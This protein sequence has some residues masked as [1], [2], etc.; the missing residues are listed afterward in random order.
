ML[1]A[2]ERHAVRGEREL[3]YRTGFPAWPQAQLH[4]SPVYP[5]LVSPDTIQKEPSRE[6]TSRRLQGA[7]GKAQAVPNLNLRGGSRAVIETRMKNF[8]LR[9]RV[10]VVIR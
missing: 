3:I 8:P 10:A 4:L 2:V 9:R 5:Q 6:D 7:F 1:V